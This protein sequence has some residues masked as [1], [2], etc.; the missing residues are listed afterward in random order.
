MIRYLAESTGSAKSPELRQAL[1]GLFKS[2]SADVQRFLACTEEWFNRQMERVTGSYKCWVK[3]W[4]L[5]IATVVVVAAGIDSV[6]IAR[7]CTPTRRSAAVSQ[8]TSE[9]LIGA[10]TLGAPFW[11]RLLDRV[12]TLSNTDRDPSGVD[13]SRRIPVERPGRDSM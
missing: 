1:I 8:P 9:K 4:V 13:L 7:S 3:K 12:G 11:Y 6:A 5:V 2:A 10:A